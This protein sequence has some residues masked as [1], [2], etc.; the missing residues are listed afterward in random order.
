MGRMLLGVLGFMRAGE[1]TLD[2]GTA[3]PSICQEDVAVDFHQHPSLVRIR[4]R[5]A[6]T[7]PFGRGISIFVSRTNVDLAQWQKFLA[8]WQSAHRWRVPS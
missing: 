7:N 4:L 1:F 3:S 2:R 5:R 8:I 6:K